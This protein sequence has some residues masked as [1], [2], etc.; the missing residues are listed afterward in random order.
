MTFGE[1]MDK[2]EELDR[3]EG[4][5]RELKDKAAQ[6]KQ[7]RALYPYLCVCVRYRFNGTC[8]A[9]QAGKSHK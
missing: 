5:L 2:R 1:L 4:Q 7:A 8:G 9:A 3:R 6:L